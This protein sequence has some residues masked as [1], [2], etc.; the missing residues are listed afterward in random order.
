MYR[1][2][3]DVGGTFTDFTLLNEADGGV[4]F[5]KVS[6]TPSDP[7]RAI[8]NGVSEMLELFRIAPAEGAFIGHGTTLSEAG[9]E[10]TQ[11]TIEVTYSR[12]DTSML[13]R[14]PIVFNQR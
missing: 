14:A 2:G 11:F 10:L 6:S 1:I 9:K 4:R 13:K 7:S 12:P 5:H 3:V 8:L